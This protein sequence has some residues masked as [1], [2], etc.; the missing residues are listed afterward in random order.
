MISLISLIGVLVISL[1][2][3][4]GVLVISLISL[5]GVLVIGFIGLISLIGLGDGQAAVLKFGLEL[6]LGSA[7]ILEGDLQMGLILTVDGKDPP[8]G[9]IRGNEGEN[10]PV[11]AERHA[12]SGAHRFGDG[13]GPC[14]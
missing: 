10:A 4:I 9:R 13:V 11:G 8:F 2:S 1:I 5:I 6:D 3:L 7:S 14:R 12:A